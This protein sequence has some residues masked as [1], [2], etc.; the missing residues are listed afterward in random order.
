MF[1]LADLEVCITVRFRIV[2]ICALV[3]FLVLNSL[4]K[5]V[6]V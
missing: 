1:Y 5:R 2:R 6:A 3:Q 4:R